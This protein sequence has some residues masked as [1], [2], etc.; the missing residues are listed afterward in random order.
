[1]CLRRE[2]YTCAPSLQDILWRYDDLDVKR[3]AILECGTEDQE[4]EEE[5]EEEE[6]KKHFMSPPEALLG[7]GFTVQFNNV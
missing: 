4:E 1:M 2:L 5:E 7:Y 3:L 6:E